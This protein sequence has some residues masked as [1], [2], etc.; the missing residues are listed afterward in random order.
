MQGVMLDITE[1]K[2]AEEA[3]RMTE[4]RFQRLVEH[5]PQSTQLFWP[6]GRTR[7]IN[8]A[9]TRLFGITMEQLQTYNILQDPELARLGVKP[10]M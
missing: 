1:R 5:S 10:L 6:D 8:R 3:R 9:F 2:R 7:Q 4:F